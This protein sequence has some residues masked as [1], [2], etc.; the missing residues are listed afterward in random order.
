[1]GPTRAIYTGDCSK[2][3]PDF[4]KHEAEIARAM[5]Q[6]SIVSIFFITVI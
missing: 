2:R 1:M 4:T 5:Q 6:N 3:V